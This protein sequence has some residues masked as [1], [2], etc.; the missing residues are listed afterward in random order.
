[1]HPLSNANEAELQLAHPSI[2]TPPS[3]LSVSVSQVTHDNVVVGR[4][5]NLVGYVMTSLKREVKV[6]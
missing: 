6:F 5:I 4:D 1:M 2:V 3:L